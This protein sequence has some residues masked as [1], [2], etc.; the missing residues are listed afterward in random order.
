MAAVRCKTEIPA[1]EGLEANQMSVGRHMILN[2]EGEFT[3][4]FD[5]S[6]AFIKMDENSKNTVRVFKAEAR[7]PDSFDVNLTLYAAGQ[8]QFPDLLLS[9]GTNEI[10]L[11]RQQFQVKTVLEK[12]EDGKPPP[13]FGPVLPLTL[14]WPPIYAILFFAVLASGLV[15]LIL[16]LRR[17]SRLKRLI[18]RLKTH[19][20]SIDADVQFYRTMRLLEKSGYPVSE[21]EEAFRLYALRIFQLPLFDLNNRQS[22]NFLKK[23]RPQFKKHRASLQKFLGDFE[24]LSKKNDLTADDKLQ[25][26]KRLY[27]FVDKMTVEISQQVRR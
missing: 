12:T 14:A 3:K 10:S 19:D 20:S 24:V 15:F 27:R 18:D 5:F 17:R 11:G 16:S 25:L 9:D 7:T 2:C 6:K 22:L 21:M 4:A 8:Y 23:R 26:A 1:V 13:P